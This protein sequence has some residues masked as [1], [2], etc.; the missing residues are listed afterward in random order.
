MNIILSGRI[1]RYK[2]WDYLVLQIISQWCNQRRIYG[3]ARGGQAHPKILSRPRYFIMST[4]CITKHTTLFVQVFCNIR[5]YIRCQSSL[6]YLI[7]LEVS[8]TEYIILI[9]ITIDYCTTS[10]VMLTFLTS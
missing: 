3:G 1:H 7:C 8:T 2:C 10:G 5:I 4:T 6:H 9:Y